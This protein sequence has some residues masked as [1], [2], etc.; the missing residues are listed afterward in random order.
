GAPAA[1]GARGGAPAAPAESAARAAIALWATLAALLLARLLLAFVPTMWLWGLNVQ[2]F[3]A[4]LPAWGLW[5]V[6]LLGLLPPI[7]RALT[8]PLA[9]L[10]E[11]SG[12][13]PGV[14]VAALFAA[15]LVL[16]VP[17]PGRF[18][19]DFPLPPGAFPGAR[20]SP[21]PCAPAR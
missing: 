7:A 15:R 19:R 14:A 13:S 12:G 21:P 17:D 20:G 16:A 1:A 8:P 6:A 2:R 9:R 11:A 10:G 4:P 3:L 18:V 5:I